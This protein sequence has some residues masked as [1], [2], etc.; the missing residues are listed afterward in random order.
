MGT[1]TYKLQ[2]NIGYIYIQNYT[3]LMGTSTYKLQGN[4]GY[5]YIQTTQ[6]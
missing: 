2:G 6:N 4:N 1:S 3:E 5:I